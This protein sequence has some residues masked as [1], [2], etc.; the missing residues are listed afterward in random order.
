MCPSNKKYWL[1]PDFPL[2]IKPAVLESK[3]F[4]FS[5]IP[6]Y[7]QKVLGSS[8]VIGCWWILKM[9]RTTNMVKAK[10]PATGDIWQE[11]PCIKSKPT[12]LPW[13]SS[14]ILAYCIYSLKLVWGSHLVEWN[15]TPGK[16]DIVDWLQILL[17]KSSFLGFLT[18]VLKAKLQ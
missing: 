3:R 13:N 1:C 16:G 6:A 14:A 9:N 7:V 5:C 18:F 11:A 15:L 12:H 17:L 8:W 10:Q 4:I 2:N